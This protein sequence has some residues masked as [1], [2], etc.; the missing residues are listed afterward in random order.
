MHID[1]HPQQQAAT[2]D[3]EESIEEHWIFIEV[4]IGDFFES[5]Y[6]LI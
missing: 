3:V 4:S 6:T 5:Q 1:I 2:N